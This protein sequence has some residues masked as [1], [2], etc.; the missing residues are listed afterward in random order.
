MAEQKNEQLNV[1]ETNIN[2]LTNYAK[3]LNNQHYSNVQTDESSASMQMTY[4]EVQAIIECRK[5]AM[6]QINALSVQLKKRRKEQLFPALFSEISN[7]NDEVALTKF[8]IDT[9]KNFEITFDCSKLDDIDQL[10]GIAQTLG[11]TVNSLEN[12]LSLSKNQVDQIILHLKTLPQERELL[13]KVEA[14]RSNMVDTDEQ[15]PQIMQD[16]LKLVAQ[17][18]TLAAWTASAGFLVFCAALVGYCCAALYIHT[19]VIA[20]PIALLSLFGG[21]LLGIG[22]LALS[23]INTKNAGTLHKIINDLSK[24]NNSIQLELQLDESPVNENEQANNVQPSTHVSHKQTVHFLSHIGIYGKKSITLTNNS[25]QSNLNDT[26]S[27]GYEAYVK[28]LTV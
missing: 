19:V 6:Q 23:E 16:L 12:K 17:D 2:H 7:Q 22:L 15:Y 26:V 1:L 3:T 18:D 4:F 21:G 13:T 5:I 9:I 20:L 28:S 11:I 24:L 14:F 10:K 25:Q 27:A 8:L